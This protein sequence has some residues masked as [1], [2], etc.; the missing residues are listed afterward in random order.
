Q[1]MDDDAITQ[2]CEAGQQWEWDGVRFTM[3]HPSVSQYDIPPPKANDL[4]CVLHVESVYGSVL[5]T[6]DIEAR[7]EM[8][9]LRRNP[10]ALPADVLIV[11]HHGSRTSSTPAFIEA[12][13]P[14]V[15]VFT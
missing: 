14:A 7:S 2:R 9:L 13:A 1:R 15:A 3:L 10:D 5:L 4:S 12:V 11:P 6:G 8:E